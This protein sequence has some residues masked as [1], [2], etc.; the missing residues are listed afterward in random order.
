VLQS[1]MFIIADRMLFLYSLKCADSKHK[2]TLCRLFIFQS[3]EL[4]LC[5]FTAT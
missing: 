5:S 4:R 1:E 3:L 2:H